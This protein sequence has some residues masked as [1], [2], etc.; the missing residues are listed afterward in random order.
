[1]AFLTYVQQFFRANTGSVGLLHPGGSQA[2][3]RRAHLRP[4]RAAALCVSDPGRALTYRRRR[5][6]RR[7]EGDLRQ[8]DLL[9]DAERLVLKEVSFEALPGRTVAIV[10]PTGGGKTTIINLLLHFHRR[11]RG[12]GLVTA[13]TSVLSP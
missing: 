6:P 4:G 8:G 9:H 10:G 7:G 11:R 13:S 2:A 3:C 5:R 1:M 12:C